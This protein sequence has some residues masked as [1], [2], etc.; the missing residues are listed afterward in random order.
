[1]LRVGVESLAL[2][3]PAFLN[4]NR[5]VPCAV[6]TGGFLVSQRESNHLFTRLVKF[7][8]NIALSF[9][10][11][12]VLKLFTNVKH[13]SLR[14]IIGLSIYNVA[15]QIF[16]ALFS[17]SN[18]G[19]ER[20]PRR[21]SKEQYKLSENRSNDPIKKMIDEFKKKS[22]RGTNEFL[23]SIKDSLDPAKTLEEIVKDSNKQLGIIRLILQAKIHKNLDLSNLDLIS[24]N[25]EL[26]EAIKKLSNLT[27]LNLSGNNFT[28]PPDWITDF[29][30]LETLDLSG[31]QLTSL[32]NN[33]D[34]LSKLKLLN[35][36]GN[37]L[38]EELLNNISLPSRC[39]LDF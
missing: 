39:R 33:L 38:T 1:M 18:R 24:L 37:N 28:S 32:P 19:G 34:K 36:A 31:N 27:T 3:A 21:R 26:I 8:A 22:E 5:F 10:T 29:P 17:G 35:V 7:V 14:T 6:I 12:L 13:L 30:D 23:N 16:F 11:L 25:E 9:F 4:T 2:M 15:V 20:A